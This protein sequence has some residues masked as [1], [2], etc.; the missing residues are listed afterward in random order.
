M[1]KE[2]D[3]MTIEIYMILDVLLVR[4]RLTFMDE[5]RNKVFAQHEILKNY[6]QKG[7]LM[8]IVTVIP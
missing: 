3:T 6:K 1:F 8:D 2:Y 7:M 5:N 4:A